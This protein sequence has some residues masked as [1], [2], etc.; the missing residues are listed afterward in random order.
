MRVFTLFWFSHFYV[1]QL[2]G[3]D[4]T[5][6]RNCKNTL[7]SKI[8]LSKIAE[9]FSYAL[10]A[11]SAQSAHLYLKLCLIKVARLA[12]FI[13]NNFAIA[14]EFQIFNLMAS[15]AES[16]VIFHLGT[17]TGFLRFNWV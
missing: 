17:F 6:Y 14:T 2:F 10:T 12:T 15:G 13:Y 7:K 9:L 5:I 16:N 11:Q 8:L 1:N 4:T 3:A